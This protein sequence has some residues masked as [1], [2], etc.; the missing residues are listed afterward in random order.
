MRDGRNV[1][2]FKKPEGKRPVMWLGDRLE[3]GIKMSFT[4]TEH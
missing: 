4:E 3:E 1:Y 2:V